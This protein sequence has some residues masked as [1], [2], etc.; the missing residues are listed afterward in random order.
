MPSQNDKMFCCPH[1]SAMLA[2]HKCFFVR[3]YVLNIAI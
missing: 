2:V 3:D 1:K